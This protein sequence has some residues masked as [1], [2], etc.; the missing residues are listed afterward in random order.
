LRNAVENDNLKLTPFVPADS[1]AF[2][3]NYG[4]SW[5]PMPSGSSGAIRVNASGKYPVYLWNM[6]HEYVNRGKYIWNDHPLSKI[7]ANQT[8]GN[9]FILDR[10]DDGDK[11]VIPIPAYV[12]SEEF[13]IMS[14]TLEGATKYGND[15]SKGPLYFLSTHD[16][17]RSHATHNENILLRELYKYSFDKFDEKGNR[18][19]ADD[20]DTYCVMPEPETDGRIN[21]IPLIGGDGLPSFWMNTRD[22]NARGIGHLDKIRIFNGVGACLAVAFHND[23]MAPG[24]TWLSQGG[25]TDFIRGTDGKPILDQGG[26]VNSVTHHYHSRTGNNTTQME[27]YVYVEKY[28]G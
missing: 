22:A 13:I 11:Y 1:T 2:Q 26:C 14:G 5:N 18:L 20:A 9:Y 15:I 28:D 4:G 8:A 25:W 27:V 21:S 16:K 24:M 19:L 7:S 23:R 12:P 17:Y 6:V 10:D 3:N